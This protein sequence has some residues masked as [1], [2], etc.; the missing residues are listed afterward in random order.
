MCETGLPARQTLDATL[1]G[2]TWQRTDY[3]TGILP[4]LESERSEP[5]TTIVH[6]E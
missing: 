1:N 3:F 6:I 5:L 2:G 4:V